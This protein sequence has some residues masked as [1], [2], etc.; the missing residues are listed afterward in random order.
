MKKALVLFASPHENGYTRRLLQEFLSGLSEKHWNVDFFDAYKHSIRP[1][2]ACGRCRT[3]AQ[4]IYEDMDELDALL[5]KC[6]LV[7]VASPVYN[8]S[9]PAPLKAVMDRF[10]R[11]FEAYFFNN[12]RQ[13]IEK[14]RQ[15]V[16]LFT[17]GKNDELATTVCEKALKQSFSVMN[18]RLTHTL[19]LPDTD[20]ASPGAD[21]IF[22][23]ARQLAIEIEN[24]L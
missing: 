19:C 7:I 10:Q 18:I 5:R 14:R 4:C 8:L 1:C 3:D 11:Y 6:D 23:K 12:R 24:K 22:E 20:M 17:M 9:F 16:L 13:P 21:M 15:A 2:I